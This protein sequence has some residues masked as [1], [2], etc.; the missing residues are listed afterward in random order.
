[1][2]D[3]LW[4]N[5][6]DARMAPSGSVRFWFD[7]WHDL[8]ELGGGSEQGLLNSQ[9][10]PAQWESNLGTQGE[11]TV[12]WMQCMGVD[13]LFVSDKRSQEVFKD[14]EHPEKIAGRLPVLYDD[15]Q[16]NII[17]RVPRR[18]PARARIVDTA[19]FAKLKPQRGNDDTEYLGY[20]VDAIEKGPDSL[21]T[22]M[23]EGPDAMLV[24]AQVD[25]G[26][27]ILVQEAYDP[28]WQATGGGR[29]LPIR[30]DVMGF[31]WIAAP[32]GDDEIHLQFLTPLENQIGRIA[33]LATLLVLLTMALAPRFWER[34]A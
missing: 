5:L 22:L 25:A 8:A 19:R 9:V 23:R 10:V 29:V 33:T 28:A 32:P 13:A 27:S 21:P 11:P 12:L 26:Q 3:W 17:Y 14:F 4:K 30:R 7:A 15:G 31:M 16:G 20:Y 24:H 34:L 18:F 1:M 6:P 2:S